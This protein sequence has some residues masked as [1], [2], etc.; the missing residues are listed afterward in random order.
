MVEECVP[1]GEG[2]FFNDGKPL[3]TIGLE[4]FESSRFL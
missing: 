1:A 2:P 4:L 3:A